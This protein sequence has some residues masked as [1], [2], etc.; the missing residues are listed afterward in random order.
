[1]H[2]RNM[3]PMNMGHKIKMESNLDQSHSMVSNRPHGM[4]GLINNHNQM[5]IKYPMN[6]LDDEIAVNHHLNDD[7]ASHNI[8]PV[9]RSANFNKYHHHN[10]FEDD[11]L[12][13]IVVDYKN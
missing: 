8:Y 4:V 13:P 5:L 12:D 9:D 10:D 11:E 6:A 3:T 2:Q 1:M 7:E